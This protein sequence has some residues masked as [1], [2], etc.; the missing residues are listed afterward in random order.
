V[1]TMLFALIFKVL[2]DAQIA[3]RNVWIGAVVTAL[4]FEVGKFGLSF[5]LGR[6]STQ[7][8]FGAAGS[9]VLLL[10]WVYYASCIMLFGA[11]F[12]QVYA[13][14]SG[15]QIVPAPG[16]EAVTPE[17]RAQQGLAP[18]ATK[19]A[20]PEPVY[21]RVITIS[22]APAE[23]SPIGVLLA[24]TAASFI[25]G[26]LARRRAEEVRD[27]T[28]RIRDGLTDLGEESMGRVSELLRRGGEKVK[29]R[30]A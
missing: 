23:S 19:A 24:V 15:H 25:V 6:E 22:A 3:W 10:L 26:L 20:N 13:R 4:L 28:A 1:V 14:N 27:P 9:V 11:E 30:F 16:A 2:P 17:S 29:Q 12:T 18:S 8:S 7:S 21:T 5:Y